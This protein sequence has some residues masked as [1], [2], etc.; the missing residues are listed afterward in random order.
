MQREIVNFVSWRRLTIGRN[1]KDIG[2]V[3]RAFT[4]AGDTLT[5]EPSAANI[6]DNLTP[7]TNVGLGEVDLFNVS[8]TDLG[9]DKIATTEEIYDLARRRGLSLCPPQIG[10]HLRLDYKYQPPGEVLLIAMETPA[11]SVGGLGTLCLE[12]VE[13]RTGSPEL[14]LRGE[15]GYPWDLWPSQFRWIFLKHRTQ[16]SR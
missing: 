3:R 12:S 7:I 16:F 8:S 9:A 13:R 15:G 4:E 14:L 1:M 2:D 5:I 11:R 10:L 6:I